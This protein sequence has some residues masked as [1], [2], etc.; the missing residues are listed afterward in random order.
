MRA[1]P[2]M[3]GLMRRTITD[4]RPYPEPFSLAQRAVIELALLDG[5]S[6][7]RQ[8]PS[9]DFKT[10]HEVEINVA[11]EQVLNW[12]LN[13][14]SKGIRGF[15]KAIFETIV[16]GAELEDHNL[17]MP[18]KRPDFAFR[19][20]RAWPGL[21]FPHQCVL[22]VECKLIDSSRPMSFYCNKGLLRFVDGTYAWAVRSAYMLGYMRGKGYSPMS[23]LHKHLQKY[24]PR[25][26]LVGALAPRPGGH[27][28]LVYLSVHGR[29]KVNRK[30]G[31]IT[32]GHLWV[33]IT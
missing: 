21:A 12:M 29:S 8:D 22:L 19:S 6:R 28:K 4:P 9:I 10:C 23:H 25:Y 24:G 18:E 27:A 5:I 33:R 16:R 32:I 14:P 20:C 11:L 3:R 15:S 7:V 1:A 13:N 26:E 30:P 31:D 2:G 17:E